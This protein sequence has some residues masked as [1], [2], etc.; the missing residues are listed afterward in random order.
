MYIING[1]SS[2]SPCK[3][4]TTVVYVIEG[5]CY[6]D[7][8]HLKEKVVSDLVAD[9]IYPY[10]NVI[11]HTIPIKI[12][13]NSLTDEVMLKQM[14]CGLYTKIRR[15]SLSNHVVSY[16]NSLTVAKL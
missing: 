9:E 16:L 2:F 12:A 4:Y 14:A 6:T 5:E 15:L 11:V 3:S 10:S 13:I 7:Y 8:I 1:R